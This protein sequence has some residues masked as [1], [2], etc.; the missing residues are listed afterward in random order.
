MCLNFTNRSLTQYAGHQ[1]FSS[2]FYVV[3]Y[4]NTYDDDQLIADKVTFD[5]IMLY[6]NMPQPGWISNNPL[7][8][9]VY[10]AEEEV[11]QSVLGMKWNV[12]RTLHK[13]KRGNIYQ[14]N[15]N[16]QPNKWKIPPGVV[17]KSNLLGLVNPVTKR[18][19]IFLQQL[20]KEG[21]EWVKSRHQNMLKI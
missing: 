21:Y 6:V 2:K 1:K 3:N 7:F 4:V 8:Y 20:W 19:K 13:L 14:R 11:T 16:C 12:R 15:S 18:V 17:S 9:S 5:N 10:Q